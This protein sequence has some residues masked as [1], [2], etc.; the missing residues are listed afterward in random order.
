MSLASFLAWW[1]LCAKRV[2]VEGPSMLPGLA[3]GDRLLVA[4]RLFGR[5]GPR[6]TPGDL[7]VVR[8]PE[9]SGRLIVKRVGSAR[10]GSIVV[11]GDNPAAS[12]DS[13]SFGPVPR[14][15]AVGRAWYRYAPAWAAGRLRPGPAG[16]HLGAP[17]ERLAV[18]AVT[19]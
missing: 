15:L 18:G 14:E 4:R 3:P 16:G 1:A 2:E 10:G 8:D 6:L 7:A 13:R 9:A 19:R 5:R 12:R 17:R 11:L